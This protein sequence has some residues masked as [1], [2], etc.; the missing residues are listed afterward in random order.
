MRDLPVLKIELSLKD[1]ILKTYAFTQDVIEIGRIPTAD[2]FIDNTG[3]SRA[4]TRIEKSVGGPYVVK[5][6]GST[7]GTYVNDERIREKI[8]ENN[9]VIS[10]NKF[11]MQV[12]VE[13][14]EMADLQRDGVS[15]DAFEGTTV[16]N[17][18]QMARLHTSLQNDPRH[19]GEEA[20][21]RADRRQ[22]GASKITVNQLLLWGGFILLG[23]V[24]GVVLF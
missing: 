5:D 8:L 17:T 15:P 19:N 6:L 10:I 22:S 13:E 1:K 20:G 16:L 7:N 21:S 14:A 23:F 18:E 2:I 4:H 12:S 24:I 3:V 11:K 9:D